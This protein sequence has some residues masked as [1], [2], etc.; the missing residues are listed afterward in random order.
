M[1][2]KLKLEDIVNSQKTQF[3]R[4]QNLYTTTMLNS[5]KWEL[6]PSMKKHFLEDQGIQ[7]IMDGV[8]KQ[9]W[10]II[11]AFKEFII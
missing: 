4:S 7:S 5:V 9:V 1:I 3:M 2:K 6:Y 8:S 11:P 10:E